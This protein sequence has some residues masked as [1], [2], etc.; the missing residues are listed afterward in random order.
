[1]PVNFVAAKKKREGVNTHIKLQKAIYKSRSFEQ[2][3]TI[4]DGI[5]PDAQRNT[6]FA[7]YFEAKL[8]PRRADCL[9]VFD[10]VVKQVITCVLVEFKTTSRVVFDKRKKDTVQQ[11]QLHQGEEQVRDSVKILSSVTGRGCNLRVCGFLLFYQQSTL[12]VLYKTIPECTVTLTDRWAFSALLS[13]SKNESFHTFLQKS[14][15]SHIPSA[16]KELPGVH[17]SEKQADEAAGAAKP[18]RKR[19][20]KQGLSGRTRKGD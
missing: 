10:D 1:M 17:K 12:Q 8:G 6:P 13:K 3:N 20:P 7:T 14:C 19:T 9:I 2:I 15:A 5:L 4:L 16:P 18:T 11:Y